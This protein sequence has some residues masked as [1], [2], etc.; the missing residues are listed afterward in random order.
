MK[1]IGMH[2][3]SFSEL[4]MCQGLHICIIA[5]E[6]IR[7]DNLELISL[8]VKHMLWVLIR[9]TSTTYVVGTH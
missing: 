1:A 6:Q 7:R 5:V 8:F 9:I 3:F 4:I 2:K